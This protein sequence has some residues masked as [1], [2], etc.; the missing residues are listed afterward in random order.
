V[1]GDVQDMV[2]RGRIKT[3]QVRPFSFGKEL[4]EK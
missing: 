1:S 3:S 2:I 4:S